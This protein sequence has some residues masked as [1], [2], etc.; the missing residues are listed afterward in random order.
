ME[1]HDTTALREHYER[2]GFYIH[3]TSV[4][5]PELLERAARGI[6]DV[7]EGIYDMG[8]E[9][10]ER[11]WTPGD[12]LQALCKIEQP[13]RVNRALYEALC[14]PLLGQLA[15]EVTGAKMVQVWWLQL[16]YKPSTPDVPVVGGTTNVGWHQD[17]ASWQ[18][19]DEGSELFTAWLA[20]SDVTPDAGPMVFDRARI[21]RARARVVT[22]SDKTSMLS[23]QPSPFQK[24]NN[25][26]K[27][28]T[29]CRRVA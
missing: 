21:A 26:G 13:Q 20:L 23:V 22:A 4:L 11:R 10:L 1:G 6:D 5:P 25:G 15:A 8:E 2:N 9:P 16:L 18:V 29:C 27:S 14:S 3:T 24:A 19:W 28:S 12:E 17:Q 7:R